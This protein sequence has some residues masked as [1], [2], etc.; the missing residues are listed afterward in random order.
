MNLDTEHIDFICTS[1]LQEVVPSSSGIHSEK[2]ENAYIIFTS[3]STGE[4]KG[5]PRLPQQPKCFLQRIQPFG[6][7]IGRERPYAANVRTNL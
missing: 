5:V 6:L 3:G 7:A 2:N 4:P 1:E